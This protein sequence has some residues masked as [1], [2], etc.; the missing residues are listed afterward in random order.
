MKTNLL[1]LT[2]R[3]VMVDVYEWE[4]RKDCEDVDAAMR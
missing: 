4:A 2:V 1:M 3:G